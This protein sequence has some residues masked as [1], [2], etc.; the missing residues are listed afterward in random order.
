M[1]PDLVFWAVVCGALLLLWSFGAVLAGLL[2][3]VLATASWLHRR[4]YSWRDVYRFPCWM[5]TVQEPPRSRPMMPEQAPLS[6][7]EMAVFEAVTG[8]AGQ[9]E[10]ERRS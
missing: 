2:R 1:S 10:Q 3:I 8:A 9:P 7:E 6:G 4:R 5:R